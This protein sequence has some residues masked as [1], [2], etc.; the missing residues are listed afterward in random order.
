MTF[1][2]GTAAGPAAGDRIAAVR[3]ALD[4]I[5]DPCSAAAGEPLGL[6]DMG[7]V[8]EVAVE[9]GTVRV[10]LLPTSPGCL[11]TPVFQEEIERRLGALD[12]CGRVEVSFA[13]ADAV[14]DEGRIAPA[15]RERLQRRR[16]ALRRRVAAGS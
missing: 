12:W 3:R 6:V 13:P 7:V 14:W 1:A 4:G 15:A 10:R 9:G 2:G 8:D 16:A 5:V 11:Y